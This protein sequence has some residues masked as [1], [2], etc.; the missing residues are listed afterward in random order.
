MS[1]QLQIELDIIMVLVKS[2]IPVNIAII[3]ARQIMTDSTFTN[4]Q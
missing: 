2:G 1:D 4:L 3:M